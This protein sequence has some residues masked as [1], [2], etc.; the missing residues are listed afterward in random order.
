M[1][2]DMKLNA[3]KDTNPKPKSRQRPS[4]RP[5]ACRPE[6]LSFSHGF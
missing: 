6:N 5:S 3:G 4:L 1:M 2:K